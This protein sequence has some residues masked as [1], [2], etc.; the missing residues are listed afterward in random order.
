MRC[1]EVRRTIEET[2]GEEQSKVVLDHLAQCADCRSL[3]QRADRLAL[4]FRVMAAEATPEPSWGFAS[5]VVRR[6]EEVQRSETAVEE[7]F[8]RVG[9]RVVYATC[10]LAVTLLLALV[11]P[12][13]GPFRG[14]ATGELYFAQ[15]ESA[16]AG[17]AAVF[18][19]EALETVP[20][21]PPPA[22]Q[23]GSNSNR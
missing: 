21:P 14:P 6:A 9:R 5:R 20:S 23:E 10:V 7:F 12:A 18:M 19:G 1:D 15:V 3:A 22:V 17:N 4:G 2:W 11:L 8:L 16:R 13:S